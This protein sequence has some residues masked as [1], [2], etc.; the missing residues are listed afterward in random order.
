MPAVGPQDTLGQQALLPRRPYRT[1]ARIGG[2]REGR[3]ARRVVGLAVALGLTVASSWTTGAK[4]ATLDE[5]NRE[6]ARLQQDGRHADAVPLAER[7]LAASE[8]AKGRDHPGIVGSIN[9]LA[10]LYYWFDRYPQAEPLYRRAL[11][12][13]EKALGA[14]HIDVAASLN[15]LGLTLYWQE[16]Y[17]EAEPSF[18]RSLAIRER[19]L[20]ADHLDVA[21]SL[22]SLADVYYYWAGHR[23]Q[24][25]PLYRRALA[26][27]EAKL[28]LE[29]TLTA[30]SF[31]DIG[32]TLGNLGRHVEAEP[33]FRRA[34]A[35]RDK[36]LG[37]DHT[38][39]ASTLNQLAWS[40]EEQGHQREG[41]PLLRRA[42]A[43]REKLLGPE[44][45]QTAFSLQR[46]AESLLNQGRYTEAEPLL[47]RTLAIREKVLGPDHLTVARTLLTTAVLYVWQRRFAEAETLAKR[48]LA[49]QEQAL[50]P[51]HPDL[52][53]ALS[54]LAKLTMWQGRA[55]A[56]AEPLFKRA[57]SI[58]EKS[59]GRDHPDVG[60]SLIDLATFLRQQGDT[61]IAASL[62][63]R[64][65]GIYEKS[66]GPDS[67]YLGTALAGLGHVYYE[68]ERYAD[69]EAL[70]KR[71]LAIYEKTAGPDHTDVAFM[72]GRL[73]DVYYY[74]KGAKEAEPAYQRALD[75]YERAFGPDHYYVATSLDSLAWA[76]RQQGRYADAQSLF[77][78]AFDIHEKTFGP[79]H[80]YVGSALN[81]MAETYFRQGDWVNAAAHWQ[82]SSELVVERTRRGGEIVGRALTSKS[83]SEAERASSRFYNLV[84]ATYRTPGWE[85]ERAPELAAAMFRAAQWAQGSEAAASLAKMTARS[86]KGDS[87]L[88]RL[89]RDR[90]DLVSEWQTKD[91]LLVTARSEPQA[92]GGGSIEQILGVRLAA[93]DAR[94]ADIDRTLASDFRDYATLANPE[95]LSLD[96]VQALLG[97]QEVLVLFLVTDQRWKTPEETFI[98]A[99]SKTNSRWVRSTLGAK[100]IKDNV[101]AL[102]CG[103]DHTSWQD[104]SGWS[105]DS[106]ALKKRRA[107]QL[108]RS[109]KCQEL[110]GPI[111]APSPAGAPALRSF[112]LKRAHALYR[113]LFGD[114]EDIV[115]NKHLLV[116][117]SGALATLPF[118]VLVTKSPECETQDADCFGKTAW[119]GTSDLVRS[120]TVLPAVAS[121]RSLR[122]KEGKANA[123]SRATKPYIGFANPLLTGRQG[124]GAETASA[125]AAASWQLCS[126][127]DFNA[128][129]ASFPGATSGPP[130]RAS[131]LREWSPLPQTACEVC[132]IARQLRL[133]PERIDREILLGG[134]VRETEI[135]RL[136]ALAP[137]A[138]RSELQDYKIVHF[139][140]HGA[141]ADAVWQFNEPGLI[142]TP[143]ADHEQ[144]EDDDGYL[145]VSEVA[146]LHLDADWVILSACNTAAG[147]GDSGEA[148][149]GLA[150]AFFYAGARAVMVPHWEVS[151]NA[152]VDLT[153]RA[154]KAIAS[155]DRIG[156]AEALRIAM[157]GLLEDARRATSETT[158]A[159][160]LHPS[161]WGAF[162][163]AGEGAQAR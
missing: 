51:D 147:A 12:I 70:Y 109:A 79:E 108:A 7:A 101:D 90:Q 27:R 85:T 134:R 35:I 145:G 105:E 2:F 62:F 43:I 151:T 132:A 116:A 156:R 41:E 100:A 119:F 142:L 120:T 72:Y 141:V 80:F 150:S 17:A 86:A 75:I 32:D 115:A 144:S 78:R 54:R 140:T 59:L 66:L 161:F 47:Q 58:R 73:A 159:V 112:D 158:R 92:G 6:I 18:K 89:V 83:K 21:I 95:P 97:E 98:W 48:A 55:D 77:K 155:N 40:L 23:S 42:I 122:G 113:G 64:A 52:A 127:V 96:E 60:E 137:G 68:Q 104:A 99:V 118:N 20:G 103:L 67:Q 107:E 46:L 160:R 126:K 71:S 123:Q 110:T 13:R 106:P 111:L 124:D 162:V 82:R 128:C 5:L 57:M 139:A 74:W 29:H 135:K 37:P 36:L 76:Y 34:L 49:I 93:I 114:I 14:G 25:E 39:I 8:K 153:T 157:A 56:E 15:D 16:R 45:A 87:A 10:Y 133:P 44:H 131:R 154:I 94:I 33:M 148:L 102:R 88:A 26:I 125:A 91:R 136:G 69:A 24:A 28:G 9:T 11:A 19:V 146:Q 143:P 117:P 4:A 152:A 31:Q 63:K 3:M 22:S 149:S 81:N 30:R 1:V 50:G 129:L 130:I 53:L 163:V 84:K 38:A 138:A 65:I 61:N 121:L